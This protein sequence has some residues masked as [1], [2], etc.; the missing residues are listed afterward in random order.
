MA[1][2]RKPRIPSLRRHRPSQRAVVT[3]SG[4]D[5]YLGPWPDHAAHPPAESQAA[6]DRLVAQW[7]AGSRA[8]VLTAEEQKRRLLAG[9]D[10]DA[11]PSDL[12][13]GELIAAF[14]KHAEGYYLHPDGTATGELEN[15]RYS[16]R[17]LNHLYGQTPAR[18][19]RPSRL[20]A[21]RQLMV[22]G[23]EH[24]GYGPQP[25]LARKLINARVARIVRMFKWATEEEVVPARVYLRLRAVRPLQKGRTE[26]RETAKVTPVDRDHVEAVLPLVRPNVAAMIRLQ[27]LSGMRPGEVCRLRLSELDRSG[28]VWFYRPARHKTAHRGR[29]RVI[30]LGPKAQALLLDWVRIR[31]PLCGWEGRPPRL[32]C[33]DGALCG[34]CADRVDEQETAGPRQR[35]EVQRA[36]ACLFSPR[37]DREERFEDQRAKRRSQVQPSQGCRK[38]ANPKRAP[39]ESYTPTNYNNAIRRAC[40]KAGV[41]AWHSNRLRHTHATEVRRLYG[42]EGSQVALGHAKAD[43]SQLYAQRDLGL[44]ARIAREVG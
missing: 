37:Q 27:L 31:C 8:A 1:P 15:F 6:Y 4:H 28:P 18:K 30:A 17:P 35:V 14:W 29:E 25:A 24:P 16:F 34:P 33:R 20:K 36:D 13:V 22:D 41:S 26:A 19:L 12:T 42:L 21:V 43:V 3:L 38:T 2:S 39:G 9:L 10:P 11:P 44:A 32:G 7:L 23:Y 5:H 40:V